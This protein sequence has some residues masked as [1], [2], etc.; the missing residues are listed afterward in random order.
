MNR[1]VSLMMS[2]D[3]AMEYENDFYSINIKMIRG[4]RKFL[5]IFQFYV[6]SLVILYL[7]IE[8][9]VKTKR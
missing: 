9:K 3:K 2:V 7:V 6:V 4:K 1:I 8:H 5:L